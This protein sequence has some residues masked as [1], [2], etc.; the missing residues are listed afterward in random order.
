MNEPILINLDNISENI[1]K[2]IFSN[3]SFYKINII[4]DN[5][6]TKSNNI[7]YIQLNI[8]KNNDR[9]DIVSI[10]SKE[11]N[12]NNLSL[13]IYLRSKT[14][15][16]NSINESELFS[17]S[18]YMEICLK[19]LNIFN[20]SIVSLNDD[21]LLIYPYN[22]KSPIEIKFNL[23]ILSLIR[24]EETYYMKYGFIPYHKITKQNLTYY[25]KTLINR[26]Y[27]IKWDE[28][29]NIFYKGIQTKNYILNNIVKKQK[30]KEFI[31]INSRKNEINEKKEIFNEINMSKYN[32]FGQ[33]NNEHST[34]IN[35]LGKVSLINEH[36]TPIN[37]LGKVSLI[38]EHLTPIN[39]LGKVSLIN[40]HL[41]PINSLGKVSL[42]NEHSTPINSLK[43]KKHNFSNNKLNNIKTLYHLSNGT[44]EINTNIID[45][46]FKYWEIMENSYLL[47]R[48][49][50][51][52]Q[53]C[54]SP[55]L[56][57]KKFFNRK[58]SVLFL[59]WLDL[60]SI[61]YKR[62]EYLDEYLFYNNEINNLKK[63][64]KIP[65][66]DIFKELKNILESVN[67]I[68]YIKICNNEKLINIL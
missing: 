35:S 20:V 48:E 29:D 10:G 25:I 51:K 64:I 36:S 32:F 1:K 38:N 46:W 42:I 50:Y 8:I 6:Y 17:G 9:I 61:Q 21:S 3:K 55:F 58:D 31:S 66:I 37:S 60:Y 40:E 27:K 39:S 16:I 63:I 68:Y 13:K 23:S 59:S 56:A 18:T 47:I 43:S 34:P 57:I 2:L 4:I 14:A 52:S 28:F 54:D 11:G 33:N 24:F 5:L 41:T 45:I 53:N 67:W 7:S 15:K 44:F 12:Y 30:F 65:G 22:R 26:L 49:K 19:L 62:F